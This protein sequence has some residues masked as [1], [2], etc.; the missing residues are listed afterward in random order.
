MS[1]LS[2]AV[3]E[4]PQQP[5]ALQ[6]YPNPSTGPITVAIE[7]PPDHGD[8]LLRDALGRVVNRQRIT[9]YHTSLTLDHTGV[10]SVELVRDGRTVETQRLIVHP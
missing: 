7:Q 4:A 5:R 8:L 2:T 3:S 6:L 9:A 1:E 10:Y